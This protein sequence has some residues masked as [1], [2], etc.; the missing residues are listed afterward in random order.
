MTP[1]TGEKGVY[2]YPSTDGGKNRRNNT[3]GEELVPEKTS[4]LRERK[5]FS[6]PLVKTVELERGD[7]SHL[8]K[9]QPWRYLQ[10]E[11]RVR[12]LR[13]AGE[14]PKPANK[15]EYGKL[16]LRGAGILKVSLT[17]EREK[18]PLGG[19]PPKQKDLEAILLIPN[20]EGKHTQSSR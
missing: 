16:R 6:Y 13:V 7:L 15:Q 17:E 4:V 18:D 20:R 2:T 12:M 3:E 10:S 11:S 14:S 8:T 1:P 5:H 19:I 9:P